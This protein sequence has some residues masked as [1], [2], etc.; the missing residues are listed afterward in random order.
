MNL[1]ESERRFPAGN[2]MDIVTS[3]RIF[4]RQSFANEPIASQ[5]QDITTHDV[6]YANRGKQMRN[7]LRNDPS[8]QC[9][10]EC[11]ILPGFLLE[12]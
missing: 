6:A 10:C 12:G 2:D 9:G 7:D 8:R 4:F 1:G 5:Q 11:M 3:L